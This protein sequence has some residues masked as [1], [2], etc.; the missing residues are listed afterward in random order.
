MTAQRTLDA[1]ELSLAW[2]DGG[3]KDRGRSI[4][5][6]HTTELA[7]VACKFCNAGT[8]VQRGERCASWKCDVVVHGERGDD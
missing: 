5:V 8:C 2:K 6:A 4:L 3:E 1:L 7:D